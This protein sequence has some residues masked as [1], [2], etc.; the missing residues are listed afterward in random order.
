MLLVQK[1]S[2]YIHEANKFL[3]HS[4]QEFK[5]IKTFTLH[6]FAR[7]HVNVYFKIKPLVA[8]SFFFNNKL[9]TCHVW[10]FHC[11]LQ[12]VG[13]HHLPIAF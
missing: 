8:K 10:I 13:I 6:V 4:I 3:K 11:F 7:F 5:I 2:S 1:P 12:V 9:S